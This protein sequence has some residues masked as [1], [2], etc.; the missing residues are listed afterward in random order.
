MMSPEKEFGTYVKPKL[1][2]IFRPSLYETLL[3]NNRLI[4]SVA[5]IIWIFSGVY[6][7]FG[8]VPKYASQASV[9][10]KDSAITAGY[11]TDELYKTTSSA[12][13]N[14]VL[15]TMEL[16][17][18]STVRDRLWGEF[19][20][21]YP[22]ERD[23][24]HLDTKTDWI[25]Y[26]KDGSKL[27]Q[28]KNKPGT[29]II[30]L[31]FQWNDPYLAQEGLQEVLAA[32]KKASRKLNQSE[33]HQRYLDLTKQ[34]VDVEAKLAV[35]RNVISQYKKTHGVYNIDDEIESYAKNR[36]Q[37]EM[38]AMEA[39]AQANDLKKQFS[40]YQD[41]LGLDPK[42]A[43]Q[44]VALGGNDS[45]KKL[46]DA[47]YAATEEYTSYKSR[48]TDNHPKMQE[49]KQKIQQLQLDVQN[50]VAKSGVTANSAMPPTTVSDNT[51][52]NAVNNLL[53]VNAQSQGTSTRAATLSAYLR[54][55]DTK[56]RKLPQIEENLAN[57]KEQELSLSESL[58]SLQQKALDA[59]MRETQTLSNVFIV[60]DADLPAKPKAPTKVHLIVI[61]V[62]VAFLGGIAAAMFKEKLFAKGALKSND[63]SLHRV[64][65]ETMSPIPVEIL[66]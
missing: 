53:E 6:I 17:G 58:H 62:I 45:L 44:A 21:K 51:R 66:Q 57:M 13:S 7:L 42:A 61:S 24:L 39:R 15:N 29:D 60:D 8:Y 19:I 50:E 31:S 64:S 36:I 49:L 32:F 27:I 35:V 33:H 22:A 12:A 40:T 63:T 65:S 38:T 20:Q 5:M 16:L 11:T 9:L 59:K 25:D 30:R 37:F 18:S 23:R 47:L 43:V 1:E 14:P 41:T 55:L 52:G 28:S 46:N 4:L 26:F 2:V 48:Y 34:V 3:Q 56:M 54:N 10:I